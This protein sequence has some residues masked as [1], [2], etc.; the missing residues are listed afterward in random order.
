MILWG[1][2]V[3][4]LMIFLIAFNVMFGS[5]RYALQWLSND[6]L[7]VIPPFEISIM[8]LI[9]VHCIWIFYECLFH[10]ESY[11]TRKTYQVYLFCIF[12]SR[13]QQCRFEKLEVH[14]TC[15]QSHKESE[16][17]DLFDF[18]SICRFDDF[19][20]SKLEK[21]ICSI[22]RNCTHLASK[23]WFFWSICRFC[24]L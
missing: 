3:T 17:L 2:T 7:C 18:L 12:V 8:L 19:S 22:C 15:I 23:C 16:I 5:L 9:N 6:L 13:L 4:Y 11:K 24:A 10:Q 14:R 1:D 20:L 21:S